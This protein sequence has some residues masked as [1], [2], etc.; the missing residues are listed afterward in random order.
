MRWSDSGFQCRSP[1]RQVRTSC[2]LGMPAAASY[3]VAICSYI[4][5]MK[6]VSIRDAKNRLTS[7]PVR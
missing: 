6:T 3:F 7:S 2:W 5:G 1:L 4:S